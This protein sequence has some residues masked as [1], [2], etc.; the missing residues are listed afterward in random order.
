MGNAVLDQGRVE[1]DQQAKPR[2]PIA[3][4]SGTAFCEPVEDFD[5]VDLDDHPILDNQVRP[6]PGVDP[7]CPL[8]HWD[9]LLAN[10]PEATLSKFIGEQ[11]MVNR[12]Q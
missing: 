5:R 6:E 7:G 1:V 9:C 8:D 4:R 2:R 12:L 10:R 3:D 11:R